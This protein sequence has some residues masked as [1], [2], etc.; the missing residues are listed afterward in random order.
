MNEQGYTVN[1][2]S[3]FGNTS[4]KS[5]YTGSVRLDAFHEFI[6]GPHD[7]V[8]GA[9]LTGEQCYRQVPWVRRAVNLIARS[10]SHVPYTIYAGEQDV[11]ESA[12]ITERL[13]FVTQK[14][15]EKYSK[16]YW[17]LE[18][19]RVGKNITPRFIPAESVKP[20]IDKI[21]GLI[22]FRILF[23]TGTRDFS[24]E[25]VV[26]FHVPSDE[27]ETEVDSSPVDCVREA[28]G[29]LFAANRVAS[30]FYAGGLV[31]T[32]LI[33][34][35]ATTAPEEIQ[36]VEGFFRRMASGIRNA[37]RALGVRAGVDVKSVGQTIRDARMPELV[38]EARDDVAVGM[39]IP[40]TV[41]DGKAANFAT[42]SSEWFGFVTNTVI[43]KAGFLVETI[44]AQYLARLDLYME[45]EPQQLEIMQSVQ[46]E[47]ALSVTR[48]L[49]DPT[50]T[51]ISI[52][53]VDEARALLG[54]PE[55]NTQPAEY[56]ETDEDETAKSMWIN[57]RRAFRHRR[58]GNGKDVVADNAP[59]DD[60]RR[61][62]EREMQRRLEAYFAGLRRRIAE[63]QR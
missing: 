25:D 3:A 13:L 37:F 50:T 9:L 20:I 26:Y 45:L 41:L 5:G 40:P 14:S 27:S 47:Q 59:D 4:A 62:R 8:S 44:N 38:A 56:D 43:P 60:E 18:A 39:D 17:L 29:L 34:M 22:G 46:L 35:P 48:L 24:L 49:G 21:Q 12:P 19:N 15:L 36:R 23:S 54:F 16:A 32:T 58:N 1:V 52:I 33:T 28:A 10:V 31:G 11:T 7:E 63:E 53:D 6:T 61:R 42:A 57:W 55:R 2:L 51:G 30:K